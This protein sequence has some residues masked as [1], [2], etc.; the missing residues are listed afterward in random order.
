MN[1]AGQ[2]EKNNLYGKFEYLKK[3][4]QISFELRIDI[5]ECK[6]KILERINEESC[7]VSQFTIDWV[8]RPS[9]MYTESEYRK[10]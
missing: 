6:R 8:C 1:K 9:D 7:K 4:D 2:Q 5:D 3:T 10:C